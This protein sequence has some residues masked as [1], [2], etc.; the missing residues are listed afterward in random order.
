MA[1]NRA[2]IPGASSLECVEFLGAPWGVWEALGAFRNLW[3]SPRAQSPGAQEYEPMAR[4]GGKEGSQGR[5]VERA[6]GNSGEPLGAA[7][8]LWAP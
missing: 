8:N 4:K 6:S 7:R 5:E 2:S 1:G 3:E